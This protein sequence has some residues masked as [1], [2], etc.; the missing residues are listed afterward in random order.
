M[1][2]VGKRLIPKSPSWGDSTVVDVEQREYR[3]RLVT[4]MFG[5]GARAGK[6]DEKL[7]IR[8]SSIRGHLRY[9]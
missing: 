5:G 3:L 9:W 2:A 1:Q 8:P 7:P 4:P 6:P